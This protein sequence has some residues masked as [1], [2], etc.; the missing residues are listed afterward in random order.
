MTTRG[1]RA[2]LTCALGTLVAL[3]A[4]VFV[5]DQQ[6]MAAQEPKPD[7]KPADYATAVQPVI[8]KYCLNCHSTKAKKGSLDLERFASADDIRKDVKVWLG[9]IEQI[10]AGEMPPKEKPQP[11]ADEKKHLLAWIRGFLDAEAKARSGDPGFVPLRRLSN[12]EYNYTIRDL[13]G[14]DLQ[15][16][17]EFPADGAAGEGF[18]NAAEALTDISPALLTKYLN[19]S[20]DIADRVVLLPDG[21]R[22]SLAK[23]RRDWTDEGTAALRAFYATHADGEGKLS[24]H[25]YLLATVRHRDT[26]S[27]GKFAEVA[28]KEKLNAKYLTALWGTLT[29]K[30]PSQ[31]LDSIRAKWRAAAEKDVP[32]LVAEVT[33]V[34]AALW[35]T[36]RI[37]SYIQARWGESAGGYIESLARQVPVDP[38]A[39]DSVPL[40]LGLKPTPGQSEVMAYLSAQE[41]GTGGSVVWARPRFEAPGKP[42]LLLRDY[43]D[44]G[45]AF[46]V[47]YPSVFVNSA[48]YLTAAVEL[49]N[50]KSLTAES[51][52]K[53]HG[54]DPAFLKRWS[55]VLAVEPLAR[56]ATSI[57]RVVP[58][59]TLTLLEEPTPKNDAHPAINGW[60]KKGTDLPVL[61]A[62]SSDKVE[63]IPGRIPAKGVGVHPMPKEFVAVVWTA[64]ATM[65]VSIGAKVVHAHPACGNGVAWWIEH[66]RGTRAAVIAEGPVDLG[67]TAEPAPK[68]IDVEKGDFI[69]LAVDAKNEDHVCDMTAIEFSLTETAKAKRVWNLAA[70]IATSVQTGNP[71]PDKLGNKDVWSFV[72]GPSRALGKGISNV[73]PPAS[74]LGKWRE[75]AASPDRKDEAAKLA[76]EVQKLLAGK[77]PTQ[78]KSPDRVLYD[79]LVSVESTLFAGVDVAKLG[80]RTSAAFGLSKDKFTGENIVGS[81]NAT[82]EIK[83]PAALF[84]GREF[85]VDVKLG[86]TAGDRLVRPRVATTPPGAGTRGDGPVLGSANGSAYKQLVAGNNEF[87]RIFPL[88]TCFPQVVPTD[89]VVSLKMFHREDEPLVRLFLTDEQARHL[90]RLWAEQRFVSRQAVAE[91]DYLPQ[92]MGFTTQDTPKEFQQFFIDRKPLF[93][94]LADDCVKDEEAAV[95]KQL[96]ALLAFASRAYRRPLQETE[97]ADLLALYKAI[98]AK[99]TT[100]EEAFRGVVSRV[101]VAPAFL[102]RVEASPRGKEPG[103][104]ND[105]ELATRLSYFL[106]A[107]AP[108]EEL[109]AVTASGKLRDPK[110][111]AIQVQRMLNDAKT[112]SLAIEFGTQ[113]IHVRGFNELKEKNEKLFPTFTPELRK[114]IYEESILFFQD[115]FQNDRAVTS[116]IDADHTYL[117]ET[118]AKHYGIPDVTGP[119]WRKVDGVRKYGRGGILGL[120]SVQTKEAG[121]SRTSPVLRGNWVVETLLGEKL[122][123]PPA[124][125]PQLPEEEGADKL[126]VR[127]MVEK[128][129]KVPECAVCHVRIDAFGFAMEKYD[130]IGR[131]REKDLGGL[132]IDTHAKLK[133][134]TEFEGIDGLRNYL[135]V[136]KKDVVVRLFCKRLLGYALGRSVT[137]SDTALIDEMVAEVTKNDGKV[138]AAVRVIV[139]SPQFRMVRGSEFGDGP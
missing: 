91:Y 18:T 33:A 23:T 116:V 103:L 1:F 128:H 81:A 40:R 125:V 112:R 69:L 54:L 87:R 137:L 47:E 57:G 38:T 26:L 45:P 117:N 53:K 64:P 98:R 60:K 115:L 97:K 73:I 99:G 17:R 70:D 16:T 71:H 133:D 27:A 74:L 94:K 5:R 111:F 129:A 79:N 11:S 67:G 77:R 19:A 31:P 139:N 96:D 85:V 82:V 3:G 12:A 124:N 55:E 65:T 72:R 7:A 32:A 114:A 84:A 4:F 88:F 104:V 90:D 123:R 49:A 108:D 122:P 10:E 48:K 37:G 106:W 14:V 109:R 25:P 24:V 80:Q 89:E 2:R 132:A 130:P 101:L 30:T 51:A 43:A 42:A 76:T 8:K 29:D 44:F 75:A 68:V 127:Q 102:F 100:H 66:R 118:L 61:V 83:L 136:K 119:Q 121:A 58:A 113:W 56:D 15:P 13:T 9:I 34:Q 105:W 63:E 92:F 59:V 21:F 20:K 52:A 135:L 131:L 138:S 22:F 78:E 41:A 28:A 39:V 35:R 126:T 46:E 134:G 120:A 107:S 86:D 110:V 6:P 95:P 50:D 93:K 62:N 36:S